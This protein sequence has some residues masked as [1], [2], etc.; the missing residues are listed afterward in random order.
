M[1]EQSAQSK[2][3]DV[4]QACGSPLTRHQLYARATRIISATRYWGA[5]DYAGKL[6][7][8]AVLGS[9]RVPK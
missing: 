8:S 2:L 3:V 5:A 4:L 7:A 9:K 1:A 6:F